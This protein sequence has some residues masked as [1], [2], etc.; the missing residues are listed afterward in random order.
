MAAMLAGLA[1]DFVAR[2]YC[3]PL[4]LSWDIVAIPGETTPFTSCSSYEGVGV[5]TYTQDKYILPVTRICVL[6]KGV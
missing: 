6:A 5:S 3:L 4:P 2:G 1:L